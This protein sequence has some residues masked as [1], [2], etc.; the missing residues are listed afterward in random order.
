MLQVDLRRLLLK[1]NECD[2]VAAVLVVNRS[3]RDCDFVTT[4]CYKRFSAWFE[5]IGRSAID[6]FVSSNSAVCGQASEDIA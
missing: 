4:A 5:V 3:V 6:Y 1:R 2:F